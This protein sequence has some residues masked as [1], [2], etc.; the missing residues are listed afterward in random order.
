MIFLDSVFIIS[1]LDENEK[2]HDNA[3]EL[4][5]YWEDIRY[6]R[7]AINN[8][9]LSEVLNKLK[10]SYYKGQREKIINFLLS[11]DEIYY[12]SEDDYKN[13]IALMKKY[14]YSINYNDC[15]IL[16]TMEKNDINHI[17]SFDSDFDKAK[18]I[19]R[20]YI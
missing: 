16:I 12:V 10:K 19:K 4:L 15:L 8:V 6:Q 11:I 2:H 3:I 5:K 13:A 20:I 18:N 1:L 9:V 7:K 17:V 14:K